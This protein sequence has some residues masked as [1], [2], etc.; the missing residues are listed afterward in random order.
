[1][2]T[3]VYGS[4]KEYFDAAATDLFVKVG[5]IL[6]THTYDLFPVVEEVRSLTAVVPKIVNADGI[7]ET[8]RE[9][10]SRLVRMYEGS[11]DQRAMQVR[12]VLD[13]FP[14]VAEPLGL[15][16]GV[17][18][19]ATVPG[20]PAAVPLPGPPPAGPAPT[21]VPAPVGGQR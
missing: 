12:I 19:A 8:M 4:V 13:Q 6:S 15:A 11:G 21:D 1:M 2:D 20:L 16:L 10:H 17:Q 9:L 18:G 7:G 14:A 3:F 5:N